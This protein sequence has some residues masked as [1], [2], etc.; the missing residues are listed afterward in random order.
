MGAFKYDRTNLDTII[1]DLGQVIVDLDEEAAIRE[2]DRL[3]NGKTKNIKE[4]LFESDFFFQYETGRINDQEF[5][6]GFNGLFDSRIAYPLF[7]RAW[8]LM[9]KSIP[10]KRISFIGR[11]KNDFNVLVLSNTNKMH[12]D[13]F[14]QMMSDRFQTTMRALAHRAYYSHDIH[15]RKPDAAIYEHVIK[16]LSIDPSRALF[17]DDKPENI[18]AAQEAG[19]RAEPVARPDQIFEIISL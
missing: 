18:K 2:F 10:E 5:I 17:L 14:E 15:L 4:L 9:I 3:T 8:N 12:E 19:L 16:D 7:K 11:L 1:F 6:D 13:K